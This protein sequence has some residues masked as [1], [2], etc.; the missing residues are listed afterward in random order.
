MLSRRL[1]L[2]TFAA[3]LF[4]FSS[5]T[6][7]DDTIKV[8][9][10]VAQSP[11]GSVSQGPQVKDG[12]EVAAKIINDAGGVDGITGALLLDIALVGFIIPNALAIGMMS[13]GVHAG[14]GSALIGVLMFALGT[15]GS[16]IVGAAQDPSGC[17]MA[18]VMCAW[19]CFA[20]LQLLRLRQL[21]PAASV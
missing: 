18:G 5:L 21:Q 8:G 10:T 13:A 19:A 6:F 2:L 1:G 14:A 16:A 15:L 9:V 4:A 12:M 7:A 20:L 3:G 11:P 17:W